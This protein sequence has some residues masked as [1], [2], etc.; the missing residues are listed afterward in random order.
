M[1]C[2]ALAKEEETGERDRGY[3]ADFFFTVQL[4]RLSHCL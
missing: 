1:T 4:N 2:F 3:L